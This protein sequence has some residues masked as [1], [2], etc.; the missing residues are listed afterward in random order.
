M[1]RNV[2]APEG[3]P[4]SATR[5]WEPHEWNAELARKAKARGEQPNIARPK[6]GSGF[7]TLTE[8]PVVRDLNQEAQENAQAR[9][10]GKRAGKKP[11]AKGFQGSADP[12]KV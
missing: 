3:R 4:A 11:F 6:L 2:P 12:D 5:L 9:R 1:P 10:T 8:A 7:E